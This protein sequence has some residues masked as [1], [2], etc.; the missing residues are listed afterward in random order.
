MDVLARCGVGN[1]VAKDYDSAL[2]I[3]HTFFD[4]NIIDQIQGTD[5]VSALL[6]QQKYFETFCPF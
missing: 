1:G 2:S 4:F 6:P 5:T 3:T